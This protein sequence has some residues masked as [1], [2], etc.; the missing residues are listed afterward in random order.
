MECRE[1]FLFRVDN[2]CFSRLK[3][4]VLNEP[5]LQPAAAPA[6]NGAVLENGINYRTWG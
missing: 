2:P 5:S 3:I 6:G 1:T 4:L